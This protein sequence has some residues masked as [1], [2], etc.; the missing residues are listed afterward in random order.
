MRWSRRRV[1]KGV[2]GAVLGLPWLEGLDAREAQAQTKA[3]APYAI[4]F[5]QANGVAAEQSTGEIGAEPERFWPRETGALTTESL[6]GR[7]L[8]QLSGY[9]SRLLVVG[10]A[11]MENFPY[12]DGHARG[13]LQLLTAQGPTRDHQGGNSEAAGE[14]LDHRIGRELNG[15]GNESLFLYAGAPYGWLGGPCISYRAAGNR[16]SALVDPASAYRALTGAPVGG[17][18][19]VEQQRSL[20]QT[21]IND[22]VRTELRALLA[23]PQLSSSD[24]ERLDLHLTSVRDVEVSLSCRLAENEAAALAGVAQ[25][26]TNGDIV[27]ANAR[28]H[29][30]IAALAVACGFT[31]SVAIQ[32]G[33]GNDGETRYRDVDSGQ[34]MEGNFHFIS[35]RR[36]S[37]ATSG[38]IIPNSDLLHHK[39][40]VQFAQAFRHLLEKLDEYELPEGSLLDAGM[41]VWMNDLGN[42]PAHSSRGCPCVIAGSAGGFLRQGQYVRLQSGAVNHARVLNTLG[43]AA[44]LRSPGGGPIEDFGS[45]QLDRRVLS[46][47][48]A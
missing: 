45:A 30:D 9:A 17:G 1:L 38:E 21:S 4:F 23:R 5:R 36:V 19:E 6:S 8:A 10:N 28:L 35:H 20:R 29:M 32:V 37:H 43:T 42:G 25:S 15:N 18:K 13:A 40:D 11:N 2:G 22:R 41:A 39:V 24:R 16:R 48:L 44:G 27:L 3:T 7:A 12:G 26:A 34:L 31:R 33:T 46:E 14:S 47:L